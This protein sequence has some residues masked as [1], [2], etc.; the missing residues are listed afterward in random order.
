MSYLNTLISIKVAYV[1][2]HKFTGS[3]FTIRR[4]LLY[5]IAQHLLAFSI[6]QTLCSASKIQTVHPIY[7]F[8]MSAAHVNFTWNYLNN[9]RKENYF[10]NYLQG[11]LC[12]SD[13]CFLEISLKLVK[14]QSSIIVQK[15]RHLMGFYLVPGIRT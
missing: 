10:Y 6:N 15:K 8:R 7:L 3:T 2:S 14:V 9:C 1:R 5:E 4:T 11:D 13:E 12:N